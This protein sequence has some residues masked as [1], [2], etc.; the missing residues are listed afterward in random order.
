MKRLVF[1][2][3]LFGCFVGGAQDC[4]NYLFLQNG[5]TVEMTIY[6]KKG[7]E[8]GK[9]VYTVSG[10]NGGSS[11]ASAGI[12]TEMFDK[13]GKSLA[14]AQN[15]VQCT[16]G[17]LKMDMKMNMPNEQAKNM[18]MDASGESVYLDY[19]S[20][21]NVGDALPDGHMQVDISMNGGSM[22]QNVLLDVTNRK[23]EGKES[24]TT[25][26]GTWDCLKI[27]SH[28]KMVVKTVG[29]GIPFNSD[30]TE[31]FA[32]GVGIIKTQSKYGGTAITAIR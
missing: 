17:I 6:N 19:P 8:N 24:I 23:V 27:T 12:N 26:A 32:P 18:N 2:S 29:I 7:E 28:L 21:M 20:K 16:G 25:P 4:K 13:K 15:K 3:L 30:N 1:V 11:N 10:Y 5:K 22:K 14:K 31:W 9:Q